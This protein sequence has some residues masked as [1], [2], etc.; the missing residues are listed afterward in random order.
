[1]DTKL[2]P[3]KHNELRVAGVAERLNCSDWKVR[4]LI[5]EGRFPNVRKL[6]PQKRNSPFLIP[7]SDVEKYEKETY[8]PFPVGGSLA[9]PVGKVERVAIGN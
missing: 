3:Q 9:A 5:A 2:P 8:S 7:L 1:M 6:D 4:S